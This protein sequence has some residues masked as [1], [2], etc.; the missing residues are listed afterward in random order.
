[1]FL[2]ENKRVRK[3][4]ETAGIWLQRFKNGDYGSE[5]YYCFGTLVD[6][7]GQ[8][9]NGWCKRPYDIIRGI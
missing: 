8:M 7:L 3:F 4:P 1:M 9:R 2:I 6:F 5:D